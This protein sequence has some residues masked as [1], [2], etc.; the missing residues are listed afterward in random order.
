MGN[1]DEEAVYSDRTRNKLERE[2]GKRDT[3]AAHLKS[4][5]SRV[6]DKW[7]HKYKSKSKHSVFS[8]S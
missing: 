3:K 6:R 2:K 7:R 8:D 1:F 5:I 4:E